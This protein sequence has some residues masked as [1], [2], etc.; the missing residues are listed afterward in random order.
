MIKK[1]IFVV[2]AMFG[3]SSVA[4]DMQ[5]ESDHMSDMIDS[6]EESSFM[7]AVELKYKALGTK[8]EGQKEGPSY[9]ARLGW[10]GDVNEQ[11]KWGVGLSSNVEQY[12]S[13]S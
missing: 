3:L 11:I 1:S 4:N 12:F 2:L 10:K 8:E 6:S 5:S 13:T 7:G 9:R